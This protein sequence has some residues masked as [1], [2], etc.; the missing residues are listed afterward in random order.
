MKLIQSKD[1]AAILGVS[2]KTMTNY[3]TDSQHDAGCRFPVKPVR[4]DGRVYW[5]QSE[6]EN[7]AA[8]RK[9]FDRY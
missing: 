1:A 9:K 5:V 4:R 7:V 8:K 3:A 2:T 6:I